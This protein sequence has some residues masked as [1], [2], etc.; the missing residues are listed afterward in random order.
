[1]RDRERSC[2]RARS[3]EREQGELPQQRPT[4]H[5]RSAEKKVVHVKSMPENMSPRDVRKMLASEG[6]RYNKFTIHCENDQSQWRIWCR[7]ER[8]AFLAKGTFVK[9]GI[10]SFVMLY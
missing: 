3:S 8:D 5:E 1:L 10:P 4:R 2:E 6:V 7:S 9:L